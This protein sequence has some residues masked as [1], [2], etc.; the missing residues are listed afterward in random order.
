MIKPVVQRNTRHLG[1]QSSY[2]C[3]SIDIKLYQSAWKM[4]K[5]DWHD[6][7]SCFF[8]SSFRHRH[9]N[10][11]SNQQAYPGYIYKGELC[12]AL[13]NHI[14]C[15]E[16]LLK[17]SL[18]VWQKYLS[19][20]LFII[21]GVWRADRCL[22]F[23]IWNGSS[24]FAQKALAM[25]VWTCQADLDHA[26]FVKCHVYAPDTLLATWLTFLSHR[27]LCSS[28]NACLLSAGPLVSVDDWKRSVQGTSENVKLLST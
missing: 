26:N 23:F 19:L 8:S 25:P 3:Q 24:F 18:T 9:T 20:K 13:V 16:Y 5:S 10:S 27:W 1:I 7:P 14:Q 6:Q 15:W 2:Y 4:Y 11:C 28:V 12:Q 22:F 17:V 21:L